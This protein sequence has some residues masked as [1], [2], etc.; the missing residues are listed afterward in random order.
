[1]FKHT[2]REWRDRHFWVLL[3]LSLIVLFCV[4]RIALPSSIFINLGTEGDERYLRNFSF[5]EQGELYPF[6]WTKD[7]SYIKIPNLGSLPLEIVLGA[8]AAR[9]EGQPLPRVSLIAN[10]T[11]L[12]DFTMQNGIWAHQF[13]YHPPL[14]PLPKDLLLKIKSNTFVP[15]GDEYRALGILLNTVEVKPIISSLRLFQVSLLVSLIGTLSIAFSYLLL[16]W[17]GVSPKK[18]LACG[19]VVLALLGFGIVRQFNNR[20]F[21]L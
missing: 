17:L 21:L 8:D 7:S 12:A 6:R 15:S 5:R 1:M 18:S 4:Y 3:F 9:S 10:G 2:L 13:L 20:S 16:C 11:V 19:V 14:L